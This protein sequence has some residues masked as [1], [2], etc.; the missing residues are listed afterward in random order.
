MFENWFIHDSEFI[1]QTGLNNSK[2]PRA[3]YVL[4]QLI[5]SKKNVYF[6]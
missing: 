1:L 3:K 6:I 5:V 2:T 4:P